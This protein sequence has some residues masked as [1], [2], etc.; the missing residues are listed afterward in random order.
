LKVTVGN[1]H[2]VTS[3]PHHIFIDMEMGFS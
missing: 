1:F 3:Q 2:F